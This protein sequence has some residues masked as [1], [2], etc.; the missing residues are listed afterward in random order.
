MSK[1]NRGKEEGRA[2][3][4]RASTFNL[5]R[6]TPMWD[7]WSPQLLAMK[8]GSQLKPRER[9]RLLKIIHRVGGRISLES[10]LVTSG[11]CSHALPVRQWFVAEYLCTL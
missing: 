2:Q 8:P 5:S 4:L 10:K 1:E 9:N 3:E 6:D 11:L 7:E